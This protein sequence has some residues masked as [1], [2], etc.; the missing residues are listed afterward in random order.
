MLTFFRLLTVYSVGS[1]PM[2]L[3][4]LTAQPVCQ[5]LPGQW[6][7]CAKRDNMRLLLLYYQD[8]I[9]ICE[10]K[11]LIFIVIVILIG[12]LIALLS[13]VRNDNRASASPAWMGLISTGQQRYKVKY[14]ADDIF[15]I[16]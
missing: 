4:Y 6:Q 11:V 10:N 15:I 7:H 13:C 5:W 1:H 14:A 12:P 9:L 8:A 2:L 3:P 16:A